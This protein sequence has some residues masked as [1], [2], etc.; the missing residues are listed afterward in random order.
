MAASLRGIETGVNFVEEYV[1][2]TFSSV[3]ADYRYAT[4][5]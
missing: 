1:F 3:H 4:T 5:T 2:L